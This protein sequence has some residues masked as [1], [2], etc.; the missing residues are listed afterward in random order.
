MRKHG[1]PTF[2]ISIEWENSRFAELNR[3][4]RMLRQLR[5][6]LADLPPPGEPPEILFLYDRH[7]IDGDLVDRVVDEEWRAGSVP[8]QWRIVPTDGLRYYQQKNLGAALTTGEVLIFLD[9][10]VVPEPGWLRAML[11][12]FND[13]D[14]DVVGGETYVELTGV[15]SKAFA[16]TWFFNLRP[17]SSDMVPADFFH[18][19][20]VAFRRTLFDRY[21]FPDLD[22]YRGHCTVLCARLRADGVQIYRQNAARVAHP[23]PLTIGY[24]MGRALNNGRDFLFTERLVAD[25]QLTLRSIARLYR[26]RVHYALRRILENR[27]QVGLSAPGTVGAFGVA[28]A[29]FSLQAVGEAV[30]LYRPGLIPKIAPV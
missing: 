12:P 23:Y 29:Y 21:P 15:R 25:R 24:F 26:G 22:I 7:T 30:S 27:R 1:A 14:V 5:E 13:P 9:C 3:T 10:D 17:D 20:N 28:W 11:S 6:E 2:S 16:L 18:A 19:N 4:R 8:A